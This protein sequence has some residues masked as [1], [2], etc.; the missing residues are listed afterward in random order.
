MKRTTCKLCGAQL[1]VKY[2]KRHVEL[3]LKKYHQAKDEAAK[4]SALLEPPK[5]AA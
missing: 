1:D 5:E 3:H 4:K 2:I